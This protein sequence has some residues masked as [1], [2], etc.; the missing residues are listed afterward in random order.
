MSSVEA[1][2][3]KMAGNTLVYGLGNILNRALTFL[4]LPL[5]INMMTPTEYGALSLIYPFLA[6]MNVVYMYGLDAAFMRF[7]I[8][9]KSKQRRTISLLI[10]IFVVFAIVAGISSHLQDENITKR[11]LKEQMLKEVKAE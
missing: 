11:I 6:I 7:F 10:I 1:N 5:Y 3:K 9:E 2:I 4:L 8:P